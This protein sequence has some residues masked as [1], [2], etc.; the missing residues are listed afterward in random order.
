[1]AKWTEAKERRL[2]ALMAER[3][4]LSVAD[5]S[6]DIQFARNLIEGHDGEQLIKDA[7]LKGEV[8]RD[9]RAGETGNVFVEHIS[10]G[11]PSGISTTESDYWIFCLSCSEFNDEVFIGIS[12]DRLK[13]LLDSIKWEVNG[14]DNNSSKG[15]LVPLTK[16]IK[17]I[18]NKGVDPELGF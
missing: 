15:K 13:R 2:R 4:S 3:L 16:L 8:K 12:T 7:L 5:P 9:Y 10:R 1:M 11:K 17:P 18:K 14:G 6:H